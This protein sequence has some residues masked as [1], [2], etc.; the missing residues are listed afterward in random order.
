MTK[1]FVERKVIDNIDNVSE[2][3]AK[4]SRRLTRIYEIIYDEKVELTDNENALLAE[5]HNK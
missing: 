3:L 1:G 4:L 5:A 2:L